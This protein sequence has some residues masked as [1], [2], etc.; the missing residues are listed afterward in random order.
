MARNHSQNGVAVAE[1]RRR[2]PKVMRDASGASQQLIEANENT[3]AVLRVVEGIYRAVSVKEAIQIALDTVRSA[4][5]WEYASFWTVD[6]K[7]KVLR[8]TSESGTV[9]EE[10][11]RVTREAR[12]RE[13]EGLSG[14]AWRQ[15]ELIFTAD[16]SQMTDCCRAPVAMRAGVRSG[17]CFPVILRGNVIGTMDFF[18]LETLAPSKERLDALR[19]VGALVS[20]AIERVEKEAL[21]TQFTSMIN[22]Q[23]ASVTFAD[24]DFTI[25]Y[26]NPAAIQLLRKV[27]KHLPVKVENIVGQNMDIFHKNPMQQRRMLADPSKFPIRGQIVIGSETFE[28]VVNA[29]YDDQRNF[30]G[31]LVSWSCITEKLAY[32]RTIQEATDR[33]RRESEEL[34]VKVDGIAQNATSLA[35]ASVE[36]ST[37]SVQMSSNAKQTSSQ[38]MIVSAAS[39]QVSTNIQVVASSIEEMSATVREISKSAT[40]AA[41]VAATAVNVADATNTTINKLGESSAE[42]GKVIKV[43]TSIAQQTNLLALN[44]TIEAA[45]AGE[46][47]KGFAVVA[48]EVKELAKETAKATEDIGQKI[49]AIQRDTKGAVEAIGQISTIINQVNDISNSI[50]SAVEEQ[51][52]TTIEIGRNVSDA[53]KGSSEI[54]QNITSVAQTAQSTMEG[55]AN[56][57]K[58]SDELAGMAAELQSLVS[59]FRKQPANETGSTNSQYPESHPGSGA[60][61]PGK[62]RLQSP[63]GLPIDPR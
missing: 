2:V 28:L 31:T 48:N 13:G 15:R 43:I 26:A 23:A 59:Q 46:A 63:E 41:K 61:R 10:F 33:E 7:E 60:S 54:A 47:G 30:L 51:T 36:L 40:E 52:A 25:T 44:A 39:E 9:N 37:V 3:R 17:I 56:M 19:N 21:N 32:E 5:G 62:Y 22:C 53:A 11:R 57:Q 45:R 4:F 27:E 50:A 24:K 42:I 6:Q 34:K 16:I 58:A 18:S 35:E 12:F 38:A 14:R 55:A 8:F 20:G 1:K 29:A 49:D